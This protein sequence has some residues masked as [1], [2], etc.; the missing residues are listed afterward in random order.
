MPDLVWQNTQLRISDNPFS[1]AAWQFINFD[2]EGMDGENT[3]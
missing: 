1:T 2:L 3:P